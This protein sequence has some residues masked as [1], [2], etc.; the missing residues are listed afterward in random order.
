M[1]T[2]KGQLLHSI[3]W[4]M[5]HR[6]KCLGAPDKVIDALPLILAN[7]PDKPVMNVT[8]V[9]CER[10]RDS[11][12]ATHPRM[13]Y[14]VQIPDIRAVDSEYLQSGGKGTIKTKVP[15]SNVLRVSVLVK[16]AKGPVKWTRR[17]VYLAEL[18]L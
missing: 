9:F 1:E 12:A 10:T 5:L 3:L 17:T 16:L 2:I 18:P 15:M 14:S 4:S 8:A 11:E 7:W 13:M 6:L